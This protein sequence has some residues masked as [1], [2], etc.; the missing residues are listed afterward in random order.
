MDPLT[1]K[2]KRALRGLGQSLRPSILIGKEGATP[3]L[4]AA[5]AE[6]LARRELVKVRLP[7]GPAAARKALA[8]ELAAA[9]EA[10]CVGV[11]GR[12]ALLYLPNEHL[13]PEQRV[14]LTD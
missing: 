10:T 6:A 7:A 4:V 9:A 2:Q 3:G 8:E 1:G 12:T 13:P 11:V 14:R 5:T